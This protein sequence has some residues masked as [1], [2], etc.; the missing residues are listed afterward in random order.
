MFNDV[1]AQ[2]HIFYTLKDKKIN[3]LRLYCSGYVF[4]DDKRKSKLNLCLSNELQ[5]EHLV[6]LVRCLSDS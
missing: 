6:S 1:A 5:K 4:I 3:N 2:Q